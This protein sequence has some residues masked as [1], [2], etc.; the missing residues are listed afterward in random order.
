M[1]NVIA[2]FATA[3][4]LLNACKPDSSV[5]VDPSQTP[6][7]VLEAVNEHMTEEGTVMVNYELDALTYDYVD[8]RWAVSYTGG[9]RAIGDHF[10][11]LVSD[12]DLSK[13]EVV[14]GL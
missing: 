6:G 4:T 12:E 10:T 3:M 13:L 14:P 9:S 7:S 2:I 11:V 1:R 5:F 8:R